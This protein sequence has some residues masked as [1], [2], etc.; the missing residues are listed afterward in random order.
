VIWDI[1]Y[2]LGNAFLVAWHASWTLLPGSPIFIDSSVF[3]ALAPVLNTTAWLF[4]YALMVGFLAAYMAAL[5][6]YCI[7]QATVKAMRIVAL[8]GG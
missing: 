5:L 1:L 8:F 4:P 6:A 2:T 3:T 7:W